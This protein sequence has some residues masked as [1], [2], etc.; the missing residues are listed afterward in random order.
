MQRL[1]E[2]T[3]SYSS[4]LVWQFSAKQLSSTNR[5]EGR[6]CLTDLRMMNKALYGIASSDIPQQTITAML[7]AVGSY[8]PG[9]FLLRQWLGFVCHSIWVPSKP[10][11]LQ[12][13]LFSYILPHRST[14]EVNRVGTAKQADC[15]PVPS[16]ASGIYKAV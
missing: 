16:P 4:S 3:S 2:G 10:E 14:A 5:L 11:A 15:S 8:F 6:D 12:I 9:I 1:F 7:V 13:T